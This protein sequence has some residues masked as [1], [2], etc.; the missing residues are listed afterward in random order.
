MTMT[1]M[2]A[3]PQQHPHSLSV[4]RTTSRSPKTS[5]NPRASK[6]ICV[7]QLVTVQSCV[8]PKSQLW[9]IIW[10][11]WMRKRVF[12]R[13]WAIKDAPVDGYMGVT[14]TG[15]WLFFDLQ[16]DGYIIQCWEW[17]ICLIPCCLPFQ[18]CWTPQVGWF[19]VSPWFTLPTNVDPAGLEDDILKI[20]HS[21]G[22]DRGDG[23][24]QITTGPPDPHPGAAPRC[25]G[26]WRDDAL[27]AA[28]SECPA[29]PACCRGFHHNTWISC[30][31]WWI[32][33]GLWNFWWEFIWFY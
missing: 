23:H 18:S 14:T 22:L 21:Q 26:G 13:M 7:L 5:L 27:G 33:Y 17:P 10:T 11:T 8:Q 9:R 31:E 28:L 32:L 30:D 2:M 16:Y 1:L 20:G 15:W 19:S 24:G 3:I 6:S 25:R 29:V 4:R 12:A